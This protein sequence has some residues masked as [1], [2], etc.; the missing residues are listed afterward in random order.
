M[1]S[2]IGDISVAWGV[3]SGD[4]ETGADLAMDAI[5]PRLIYDVS[6]WHDDVTPTT[7]EIIIQLKRGI[8]R[9]FIIG[10]CTEMACLERSA[11]P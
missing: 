9:V 8:G 2:V 1:T 6:S 5:L 3:W 10:Y 11:Y 7:V 4:S